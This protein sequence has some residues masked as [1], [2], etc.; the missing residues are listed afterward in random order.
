MMRGDSGTEPS[1]PC[2][3]IVTIDL[4]HLWVK[5]GARRV[6]IEVLRIF[7]AAAFTRPRKLMF[8][9]TKLQLYSDMIKQMRRKFFCFKII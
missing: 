6:K 3:F 2:Y 4:S 1:P 7:R 8:A 5:C 9:W